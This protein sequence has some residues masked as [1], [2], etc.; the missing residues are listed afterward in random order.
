M[1][2][3]QFADGPMMNPKDLALLV[4]EEPARRPAC[5]FLFD[6]LFLSFIG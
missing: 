1:V 3:S 5:I 6:F 2:I 4:K